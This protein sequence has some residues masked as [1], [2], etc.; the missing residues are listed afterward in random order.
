MEKSSPSIY[1]DVHYGL[2][3]KTAVKSIKLIKK[4]PDNCIPFIEV[5]T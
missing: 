4:T 5:I 1:R 2:A 3:Q